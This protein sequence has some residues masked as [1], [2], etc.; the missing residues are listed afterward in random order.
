MPND[1]FLPD[2]KARPANDPTAASV[3]EKR[4]AAVTMVYNEPEYLPIWCSYYGKAFGP[5]RCYIIDH[6][7]DDDSL[8]GYEQFNIIRIPRSPKDNTKRTR[9]V[10]SFCSA[11]LEWYDVFLY[12]DVDEILVPASGGPL[13]LYISSLAPGPFSAYGFDVHQDHSQVPAFEPHKPVTWQRSWA[14][15][16]SSMCKVVG[17]SSPIKWSPGFHSAN[18]ALHFVE[19]FLFHLRYFDL[20]LGLR[21]LERTRSMQWA[22]PDAGSHQRVEDIEFA[23]LMERVSR[24]PKIEH[25][26]WSPERFPLA[27]YVSRVQS[28]EQDF[29]TTTYNIDLHIFGDELLPIP[30]VF[31]GD[32]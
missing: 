10:S 13:R 8:V 31:C 3:D 6:G 23:K 29:R 4:I 14:R 9:F 32:F 22:S 20:D 25:A 11:L 28:S 30:H 1:H 7:T 19:L 24:L 12:T 27:S 26:L 18:S 21:R 16:S 2:R 17:S 15:F 5:E